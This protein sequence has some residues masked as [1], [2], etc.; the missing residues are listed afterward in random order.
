MKVGARLL[1]KKSNEYTRSLFVGG[2]A[3]CP[4]RTG[5]RVDMFALSR[6]SGQDARPPVTYFQELNRLIRDRV[7]VGRAVCRYRLNVRSRR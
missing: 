6:L 3:S 4:P 7:Q 2:R 1:I 5:R